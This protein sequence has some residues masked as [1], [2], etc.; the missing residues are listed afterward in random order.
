MMAILSPTVVVDGAT[1]SWATMSRGDMVRL[2]KA[3]L[4][5]ILTEIW[6]GQGR[7]VKDFTAGKGAIIDS[8]EAEQRAYWDAPPTKPPRVIYAR[9]NPDGTLRR[10]FADEVNEFLRSL[11]PRDPD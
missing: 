1:V 5:A 3:A 7:V 10:A 2:P 8:I 6:R 11:P 9:E 4:A